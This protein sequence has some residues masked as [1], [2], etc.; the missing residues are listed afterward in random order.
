MYKHLLVATDGTEVAQAALAHG[1]DLA[2]AV[3]AKVTVVTV[4]MPWTA[5]AYGVYEGVTGRDV[6]DEAS[7]KRAQTI[8]ADA[9]ALAASRG[10]PCSAVHKSDIEPYQSILSVAQEAGCDLIVMGSHGRRGLERLLLGSEAVKVLTHSKVPVL[11][12]RG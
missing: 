5:V 9:T 7:Q 2:K 6:F 10:V 1:L 8:L 11:I 3:G 4:T 12:W